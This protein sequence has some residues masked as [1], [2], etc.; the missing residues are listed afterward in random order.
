MHLFR[1]HI[2]T[3]SSAKHTPKSNFP[4]V[5]IYFIVCLCFFFYIYFFISLFIYYF[6]FF[7]LYI[8]TSLVCYYIHSLVFISG[9][10]AR[11]QSTPTGNR[12][13]SIYRYFVSPLFLP[14]LKWSAFSAMAGFYVLQ[15]LDFYLF[16]KEPVVV[17]QGEI[18]EGQISV[19]VVVVCLC[20]RIHRNVL[21]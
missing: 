10:Q 4:L 3:W 20:I 1:L 21:I 11:N 8:F 13:Y 18:I 7:K 15:N 6:F 17:N 5:L 14:S 19:K 9:H 2:L 16:L 12:Q